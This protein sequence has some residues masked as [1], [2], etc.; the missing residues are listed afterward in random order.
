MTEILYYPVVDINTDGSEKQTMLPTENAASVREHHR[1]WL[2]EAVPHY[3]R[4]CA[5][6]EHPAEEIAGFKIHC[7][8]CSDVLSP[9]SA[10]TNKK[11]FFLYACNHC[12]K[13]K[14]E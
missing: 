4:L 2:E 14:G 11:H 9:I 10:L 5:S 7:P 13:R 8:Y 3:F 1:F 6:E 12:T